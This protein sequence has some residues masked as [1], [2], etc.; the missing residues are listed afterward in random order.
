MDFQFFSSLT[1]LTWIITGASEKAI[2]QA[3]IVGPEWLQ[4]S[5]KDGTLTP[6]ECSSN[7]QPMP[8]PEIDS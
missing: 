6:E 3:M 7:G 5:L 1:P 4:R 8:H 2:F